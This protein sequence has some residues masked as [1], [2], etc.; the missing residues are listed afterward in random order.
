VVDIGATPQRI[1]VLDDDP[2]IREVW[3]AL[4]TRAGYAVVPVS[5]GREALRLMQNLVPDLVVLDLRM[6]EMS[7][8]EFLRALLGTS[9][10]VLVVSAFV[11]EHAKELR[12]RGLN[13][14]GVLDKLAPSAE[15]LRAVEAAIVAAPPR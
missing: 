1:L 14:V 12:A 5:T 11:A 6:P 15:F 13:V 3:T 7:G 8:D 2:V 4:L 10:P 9:V